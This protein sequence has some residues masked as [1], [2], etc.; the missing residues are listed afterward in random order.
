[1]HQ[2]VIHG[3]QIGVVFQKRQQIGAHLNDS[4]RRAGGAVE[5]AEELLAR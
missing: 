2:I 1:M 4:R 3:P 5:Q